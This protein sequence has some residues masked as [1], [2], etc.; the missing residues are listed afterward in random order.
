MPLAQLLLLGPPG[1]QGLQKQLREELV[2]PFL[3]CQAPA[4]LPP[5]FLGTDVTWDSKTDPVGGDPGL[6]PPSPYV[7]HPSLQA[8]L[9]LCK[10]AQ[11]H[12]TA[13]RVTRAL[14]CVPS[15]VCLPV[16]APH[17]CPSVC[18]LLCLKT[19]WAGMTDSECAR[20]SYLSIRGLFASSSDVCKV[21]NDLLRVL[22]LASTRFSTA[23]G[24]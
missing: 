11:I 12:R 3:P 22:S 18:T 23:S 9:L 10:M 21:L 5:A 19:G 13:V 8:C 7:V 6:W 24:K 15:W 14:L 17:V 20:W 16:C 2:F 4:A 1:R